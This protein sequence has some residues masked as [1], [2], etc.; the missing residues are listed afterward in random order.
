[1]IKIFFGYHDALKNYGS[2]KLCTVYV[3]KS[4]VL[5]LQR[6]PENSELA[7]SVLVLSGLGGHTLIMLAHKG[8][9]LVRRSEQNA[10]LVNTSTL[11]I[12]FVVKSLQKEQNSTNLQL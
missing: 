9:Y 7:P 2:P 10:N 12:I 8:T 4:P 11:L 6:A 1:M 3:V 5:G